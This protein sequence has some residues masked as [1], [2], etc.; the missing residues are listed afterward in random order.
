MNAVVHVIAAIGVHDVHAIRVAPT[1]R[2]R[3]DESERVAAILEAPSI[4]VA[5][6]NVETVPAAKIGGVTGIGDAAMRVVTS[7]STRSTCLLHTCLAASAVTL[8]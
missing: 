5:S 3:I 6:V 8:L 1:D 2:P 7:V 4:I